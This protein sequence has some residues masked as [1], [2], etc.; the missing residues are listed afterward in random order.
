MHI[1]YININI[2]FSYS[3]S[4][5]TYQLSNVYFVISVCYYYLVLKLY[6]RYYVEFVS[7]LKLRFMHIYDDK[8]LN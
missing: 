6:L 4:Y 8:Q 3:V 1:L 5:S 2:L 7:V